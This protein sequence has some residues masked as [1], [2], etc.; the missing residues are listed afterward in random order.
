MGQSGKGRNAVPLL[1][2]VGIAVLVRLVFA[3]WRANVPFENGV[4]YANYADIYWSGGASAFWPPGY[5]LF[6]GLI[7]H[8]VGNHS[9][10]AIYIAQALLGGIA[11]LAT[12]G[13][14][15]LFVSQRRALGAGALMALFPSAI[16]LSGSFMSEALG[17][18]LC[19]VAAYLMW[20]RDARAN[21]W[22]VLAGV[23]LGIGVL[24]RPALLC[25]P[26]A[27]LVAG[28]WGKS[29]PQS[30]KRQFAAAC[31]VC[32]LTVGLWTWRNFV[33]LGAFVPI[34][35]NGGQDF[36]IGNHEE[37]TGAY[38]QY[39]RL[40]ETGAAAEVAYNKQMFATGLDWMRTHPTAALKVSLRKPFLLWL[41]DVAAAKWG[42]VQR[43][44]PEPADLGRGPW[45]FL[46]LAQAYYAL[47][48]ILALLALWQH[49]GADWPIFGLAILIL[50][51]LFHILFFGG[52]RFHAPLYGVLAVL[53]SGC[54][55][56]L[57]RFGKH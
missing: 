38:T 11:V 35:N 49:R 50:W 56:R 5:P 40:T 53:A 28:L 10:T 1:L 42:F 33:I 55:I 43:A 23:V 25:L 57:P 6:L 46:G 2:I 29:F 4:D 8:L 21:G 12:Y 39:Q 13:F 20:P 24:T 16:A 45:V 30:W 15:R 22:Y 36:W 3:F 34:A 27:I 9:L 41:S 19:I 31:A 47:I 32:V 51:T 26:A 54:T 44:Q 18:P 14:A 48:L 7:W 17:I 52:G 37:A